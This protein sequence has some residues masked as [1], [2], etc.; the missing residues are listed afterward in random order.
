MAKSRCGQQPNVL[1]IMTDQQSASAMSC[2]GNSDLKT[3]AMDHLAESGTRFDNAYC[4]FPL[5]SPCR[6]SMFSGR[7][8]HE[9]GINGDG[10][11]IPEQLRPQELG[12]LLRNAGYDCAYGGKW[13]VPEADL[14]ADGV[15]GFKTIAGTDDNTLVEA[16]NQFLKQQRSR[17]F[18]LVASFD[19]PHNICEWARQQT[20]PWGEIDDVPT[21]QC[22]NLPANYPIPP[23]EPEA[24]RQ[25]YRANPL[26]YPTHEY[27]DERWRHLRHAYFRLIEKVD[28]QI[29]LIID[30]LHQLALDK[31]TLVIFSSDHGDGHGEH[32][33]NQKSVLYDASS[34]VPLIISWPG[35]TQ[36]NNVERRLASNALD[37]LPTI[38]DYAGLRSPCNLHGMSLRSLAEGRDVRNWRDDL[39]VET[40][41]LSNLGTIGRMIRTQHY[42][43]CLYS[44]GLYREQLFDMDNDPGEMVNLAVE[45]CHAN[46][47]NEHRHRLLNWAQRSDDHVVDL[48]VR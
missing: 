31:D 9:M 3:P 43:Y 13:H 10:G 2:T 34:R 44:W 12:N 18:F 35:V 20:L 11:S 25:E 38:C 28:E 27:S 17:P 7:Y 47:L 40:G 6:A 42:K 45:S 4:P 16:C 22:P 8:P 19:N 14:P 26:S 36:A 29:G 33:W 23:F 41:F 48:P 5:C 21:Q 46:I 15:H 24:I 39:M 1:Y 32:H 30:T 37:L